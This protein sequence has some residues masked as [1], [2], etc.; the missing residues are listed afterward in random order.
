MINQGLLY[1][2]IGVIA[3]NLIGIMVAIF[4]LAIISRWLVHVVVSRQN[5]FVKEF[6]KRVHRNLPEF[7]H[8][9]NTSFFNLTRHLLQKTYYEVFE[10]RRLKA[11]RRPDKFMSI[12]D[13]SFMIQEGAARL[14]MDF[15]RQARY[16]RRDHQQ[17]KFL[18][19]SKTIFE[20]NPI[21]GRVF[22][23]FS[24]S[25]VNSLLA[26]LPGIFVVGGIFGTFLG[27]MHGLPSLSQMDV[28]N[29]EVSKNVMDIF[30]VK[31]A[32]AMNSSIVGILLS[33]LMN[34]INATFT[35]ENRF[36]NTVDIFTAAIEIIWNKADNNNITK[37]DIAFVQARDTMDFQAGETLKIAQQF[38]F[39]HKM[40][41]GDWDTLD[42][43][44]DAKKRPKRG[45]M[46][47]GT[48][49]KNRQNAEGEGDI[50]ENKKSASRDVKI[51]S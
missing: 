29:A 34:L 39:E 1:D 37:E 6:E 40:I 35:L 50:E 11:R 4:I 9:K 45:A 12:Y 43:L 14:V 22:G 36:F 33:I 19:L 48:R 7:S 10:L 23:I 2:A 31:I 20:N 38:S 42:S 18:E 49:G 44:K 13:R 25:L 16:L 17:P 15:L 5:W 32:F 46:A 8:R 47:T 30:L 41:L 21:F 27:I 26:I 3:D 28:T 24:V 51:A